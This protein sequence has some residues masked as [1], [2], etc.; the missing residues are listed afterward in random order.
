LKYNIEVDIDGIPFIT[1]SIL[2]EIVPEYVISSPT[3][4]SSFIPEI[5][6]STFFINISFAKIT[7]SAVVPF[8]E[9]AL[10]FLIPI[11]TSLNLKGL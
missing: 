4:G 11:S 2:P 8:V 5:T 6:K 7:Q 10:T 9:Y 3:F 1:P